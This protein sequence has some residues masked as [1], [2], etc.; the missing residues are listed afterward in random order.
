MSETTENLKAAFAG[1]SQASRK[2][3]AFAK[4]AE[5]EGYPQVAKLFRAAS[6]A[7]MVHA[8]NHLKAMGGIQ[9]TA[10]NLR[11][12][13]AGET[14]EVDEMYPPFV[15]TAEEEE[16]KKARN[17]FFWAM[18]VEKV[19]AALYKKALESLSSPAEEVDIYVCPVCGYTHEGTP[20]EKC[21]VCGTPGK[22]FGLV[23]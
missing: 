2:Y 20:P 21:P 5:E 9:G 12:A 17:S 19:H 1:E 16:N 15:A 6:Q 14:Y 22:R 13:I 3:A 10:D 4:K 18:E 11:A 23:E 8:F 7:E